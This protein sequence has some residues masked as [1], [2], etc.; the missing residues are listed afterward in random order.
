MLIDQHKRL[1]VVNNVT[2]N[3]LE[4]ENR[5]LRRNLQ[6]L[7]SKASDNQAIL[8]HYQAFEL[9]L[10]SARSLDALLH[11]LLLDIKE[12]FDLAACRLLWFDP[13]YSIRELLDLEDQQQFEGSL[14]FVRHPGIFHKIYAGNYKPVLKR[15]GGVEKARWFPWVSVVE[16]CAML[17]L[18][19]H[20]TV[21]GS[22]H[23]GSASA[24]RFTADKAVDFM[25]HLTSI[26]AVCLENCVNNEQLRRLSLIDMLTRVKNRRSFEL[27]LNKE[28]SR[29]GRNLCP[30]SCLFIDVD[31]FKRVNDTYGHQAGDVA[32]REVA[33]T[34]QQQL[35][36][37]DHLARYG[38][39]EF[40]ALL[41][42]CGRET[43]I[44]I[45]E[46]IR[47]ATENL[48]I[49]CDG[50][51]PFKVTA[52]VGIST[53]VPERESSDSDWVGQRLIGKADSAVYEAKKKG[54][55]RVCF[56]RF[57]DAEPASLTNKLS[58]LARIK[59]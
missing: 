54:R 7:Y 24:K 26:I 36:Q 37:T 39:E 52:S 50:V 20:N 51:E 29:A 16:S 47:L 58:A 42:D 46:R 1:D 33:K 40:A 34:I 44:H 10:L 2:I 18:V 49:R 22:L 14:E 5:V 8:E 21:I 15:L 25:F 12:H 59:A 17:P 28:L 23:L 13:E 3:E 11:C 57:S 53:W 45:G 38:G 43:A 4:R 35:R 30:L 27:D 9:K 56:H 32:L 55:N 19:R 6:D 31:F 48:V 41:P